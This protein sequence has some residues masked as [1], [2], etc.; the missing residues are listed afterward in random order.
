[1]AAVFVGPFDYIDCCRRGCIGEGR[2][3]S[4][5]VYACLYWNSYV[6]LLF[7]AERDFGRTDRIFH[8]L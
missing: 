2:Y 7:K 3:H 4:V 8:C 5:R 1:M 6:A